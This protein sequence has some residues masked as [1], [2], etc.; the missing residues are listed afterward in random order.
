MVAKSLK[1][2][3]KNIVSSRGDFKENVFK[4]AEEI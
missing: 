1:L 3:A 4:G 2:K